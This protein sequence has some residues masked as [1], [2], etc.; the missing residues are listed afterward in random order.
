M[1]FRVGRCQRLSADE[2]DTLDV[3]RRGE[4]DD[5]LGP[6]IRPWRCQAEELVGVRRLGPNPPSPAHDEAVGAPFYYSQV[7]LIDRGVVAVAQGIGENGA[8]TDVVLAAILY[9]ACD[10]SSEN[11]VPF[12]QEVTHIIES[13]H[14]RGQM[15]W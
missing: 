10:V 5:L 14:D 1:I 2:V 12:A 15:L 3:H 13:D 11:R 6:E 4:E 7:L 8:N 9:V